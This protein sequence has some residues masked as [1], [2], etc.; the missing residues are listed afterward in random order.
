MLSY[1][2]Y[3]PICQLRFPCLI[4]LNHL[5]RRRFT[6]VGAEIAAFES[7]NYDANRHLLADMPPSG[8]P[9]LDRVTIGSFGEEFVDA[10]TETN[11][12]EQEAW[13]WAL[14]REIQSRRRAKF[15]TTCSLFGRIAVVSAVQRRHA[16]VRARRCP[17]APCRI[18]AM[19]QGG[20][21]AIAVWWNHLCF[22]YGR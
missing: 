3:L 9:F 13:D 15:N 22:Y 16:A 17:A 2:H 12:L 19:R 20:V 14:W 18:F 11:T 8:H 4:L 5:P 21:R 7:H 10:A 6:R 1:D